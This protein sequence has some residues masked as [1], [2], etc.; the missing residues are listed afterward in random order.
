MRL[1]ATEQGEVDVGAMNECSM[2]MEPHR[3]VR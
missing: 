1:R 3:V 2:H